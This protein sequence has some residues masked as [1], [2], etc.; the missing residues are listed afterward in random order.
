MVS[1]KLVIT[2]VYSA[3]FFGLGLVLAM[4]G[5]ELLYLALNTESSLDT[6]GFMFM[7]RR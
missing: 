1:S 5:P 4:L 2:L 3:A 7:G 6:M